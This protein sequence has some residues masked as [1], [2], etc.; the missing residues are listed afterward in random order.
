M[1]SA[2]LARHTKGAAAAERRVREQYEAKLR[3]KQK[4]LN[5][6][7]DRLQVRAMPALQLPGGK[8]LFRASGFDCLGH[9]KTAGKS[10]PALQLSPGRWGVT[11]GLCRCQGGCLDSCFTHLCLTPIAIFAMQHRGNPAHPQVTSR[12][13]V[14]GNELQRANIGAVGCFVLVACLV[15]MPRC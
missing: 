5:S 15:L 8:S 2:L 7:Q 9:R 6:V 1:G 11:V 14:T 12:S 13:V 4:Q 3:E 10:M